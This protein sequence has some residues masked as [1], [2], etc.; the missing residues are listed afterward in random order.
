[1]PFGQPSI[2]P[3]A[4]RAPIE[5]ERLDQDQPGT[6][7]RFVEEESEEEQEEEGQRRAPPISR[8]EK[9]LRR[10]MNQSTDDI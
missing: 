5:F 6:S 10:R 8:A 2:R 3:L 4:L 7:S 9:E 1:M